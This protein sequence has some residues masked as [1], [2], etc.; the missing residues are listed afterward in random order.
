MIPG[1]YGLFGALMALV[2]YAN[3]NALTFSGAWSKGFSGF[4]GGRWGGSGGMIS[5]K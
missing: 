1:F 5:H 4:S 2:F 3:T